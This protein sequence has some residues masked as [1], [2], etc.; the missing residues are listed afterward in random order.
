[1]TDA[2]TP[3]LPDSKSPSVAP[4]QGSCF[5]AKEALDSPGEPKSPEKADAEA[6]SQPDKADHVAPKEA[7][8]N[9]TDDDQG[10]ECRYSDRKATHEEYLR[11]KHFLCEIAIGKR[12]IQRSPADVE[13]ESLAAGKTVGEARRA[14]QAVR[15]TQTNR[16]KLRVR[17]G[18]YSVALITLLSYQLC[19]PKSEVIDN[20][21]R[22]MARQLTER[23]VVS[24]NEL[25][26]LLHGNQHALEDL[27]IS[28]MELHELAIAVADQE[29]FTLDPE[30]SA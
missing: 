22:F 16:P 6:S 14:S 26:V 11:A 23:S 4:D 3:R 21:L 7:G 10:D 19:I 1:M 29:N 8:A 27:A 25:A 17:L 20:A 28:V 9:S 12:E 13:A 15:A 5:A 18:E 2:E 30:A 24:Q